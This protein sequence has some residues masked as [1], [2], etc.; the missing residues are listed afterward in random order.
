MWKQLELFPKTINSP[1]YRSVCPNVHNSTDIE[2]L[3]MENNYVRNIYTSYRPWGQVFSTLHPSQWKSV[4]L[5]TNQQANQLPVWWLLYFNV[6]YYRHSK[7]TKKGLPAFRTC[8][9]S[10]KWMNYLITTEN[11]KSRCKC[12]VCRQHSGYPIQ[13]YTPPPILIHRDKMYVSMD[14]CHLPQL[15]APQWD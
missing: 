7:M 9:R 1:A 2:Q 5:H 13:S 12:H 10:F 4:K 14:K 3:C 8:H 6:I 11:L 15:L